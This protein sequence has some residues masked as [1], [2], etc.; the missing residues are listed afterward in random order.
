[1]EV[2]Q[3]NLGRKKKLTRVPGVGLVTKWRL[4]SLRAGEWRNEA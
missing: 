3:Q 2:K 4:I 1:M